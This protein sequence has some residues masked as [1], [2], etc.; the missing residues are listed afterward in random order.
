MRDGVSEAARGRGVGALGACGEAGGGG[1]CERGT[2]GRGGDE[3][4]PCAAGGWNTAEA[5]ERFPDRLRSRLRGPVDAGD[6]SGQARNVESCWEPNLGGSKG[7][8]DDHLAFG[9]SSGSCRERGVGGRRRP[10]RPRRLRTGGGSGGDPGRLLLEGAA[11][12]VPAGARVL[13]GARAGRD[14]RRLDGAGPRL[15][16]EPAGCQRPGRDDVRAEPRS[17]MG[18]VRLR[19]GARLPRRAAGGHVRAGRSAGSPCEVRVRDRRSSAGS[20]TCSLGLEHD[21]LL[22][23]RSWGEEGLGVPP[24]GEG[25]ACRSDCAEGYDCARDGRG[26][27]V[28]ADGA[29]CWSGLGCGSVSCVQQAVGAAAVCATICEGL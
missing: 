21:G 16:G 2:G 1:G 28:L 19:R 10:W 24:A 3:R 7:G 18:G 17:G 25:G 12:R 11:A 14:Y 22:R 9:P 4:A 13:H 8:R 5:A 15:R 20:A 26:G 27:A 23:T 29:S 6:D